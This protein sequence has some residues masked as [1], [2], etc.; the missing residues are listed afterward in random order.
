MW[1]FL[2]SPKQQKWNNL[3]DIKPR[4]LVKSLNTSIPTETLIT[5][6]KVVELIEFLHTHSHSH[7]QPNLFTNTEIS[8]CFYF[9]LFS[10][11]SQIENSILSTFLRIVSH[12]QYQW[13]AVWTSFEQNAKVFF[14]MVVTK[15][16][17]FEKIHTNTPPFCFIAES[18]E[19]RKKK[20]LYPG[21]AI[22]EPEHAQHF[23]QNKS[24]I[25]VN[26]TKTQK[27]FTMWFEQKQGIKTKTRQIRI[28]NR[29]H[30][31]SISI[32][33]RCSM[34]FHFFFH[35]EIEWK[36]KCTKTCFFIFV[37]VL[38]I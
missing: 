21:C 1:H 8:F 9:I 28:T 10:S 3:N 19:I 15:T 36:K 34:V 2:F 33:T 17:Q 29:I 13:N 22:T 27:P 4:E 5:E 37:V 30:F 18:M 12:V 25:H 20:K 6:K 11:H 7:I 38:K 24:K 35:H 32:R 16:A 31:G 23:I 14:K 26:F